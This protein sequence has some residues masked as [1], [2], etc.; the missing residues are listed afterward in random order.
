MGLQ[1]VDAA[2]NAMNEAMTQQN[3]A[4]GEQVTAASRSLFVEIE[5][6]WNLWVDSASATR[7][8]MTLSGPRGPCNTDVYGAGPHRCINFAG[9]SA[10]GLSPSIRGN[11][12]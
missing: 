8:K 6:L 11:H 2:V 7:T 10:R 9:N 1:V 5:Q 4:V 3:A 12:I